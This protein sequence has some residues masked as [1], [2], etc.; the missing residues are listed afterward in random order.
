MWS[1]TLK[2]NWEVS[3]PYPPR[4]SW[5]QQV[6]ARWWTC[7]RSLDALTLSFRSCVAHIIV[8]R[9]SLLE[10]LFIIY[11]ISNLDHN[12]VAIFSSIT[13][14]IT[15][16]AKHS[17]II[18]ATFKSISFQSLFDVSTGFANF[19]CKIL[20]R[21]YCTSNAFT[22]FCHKAKFSLPL[23]FSTSNFVVKLPIFDI[24]SFVNF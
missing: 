24:L 8:V 14:Y 3:T 16:S 22:L 21:P 17:W 15:S 10:K 9:Y 18:L 7:W 19:S 13:L 5:H 1:M 12:S 20:W 4:R 23:N 11:N 6:E 2:A